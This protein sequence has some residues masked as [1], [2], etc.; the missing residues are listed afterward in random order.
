MG[1]HRFNPRSEW[2]RKR[3]PLKAVYDLDKPIL[4]YQPSV[5]IPRENKLVRFFKNVGQAVSI[6]GQHS[7]K[8]AE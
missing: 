1:Q 7:P 4:K 3:H 8:G 6:N 2:Y 5:V